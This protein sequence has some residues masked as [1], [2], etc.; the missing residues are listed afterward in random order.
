MS[1]DFFIIGSDLCRFTVIFDNDDLIIVI[2]GQ[3]DDR[4]HAT[5]QI[6]HMILIR[7]DD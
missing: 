1:A 6:V 4:F 2:C 3:I 5:A 7:N